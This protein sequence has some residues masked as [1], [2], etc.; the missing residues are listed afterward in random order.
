MKSSTPTLVLVKGKTITDIPKGTKLEVLLSVIAGLNYKRT[1]VAGKP[2]LMRF[3]KREMKEEGDTLLIFND[4]HKLTL[5]KHSIDS[6]GTCS[7][8][9]DEMILQLDANR[10]AF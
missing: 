10:N 4:T 2:N 1:L 9:F 3:E 8:R 7:I 6:K 5:V